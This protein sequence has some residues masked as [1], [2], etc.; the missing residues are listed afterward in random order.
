MESTEFLRIPTGILRTNEDA[1][2]SVT[3]S[4]QIRMDVARG[5]VR[6]KIDMSNTAAYEQIRVEPS[7]VWKTVF[8]TVYG[9]FMSHTMQIGDCNAPATF[10]R[11]MTAIF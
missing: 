11:L 10:Q 6:S 9:T 8:A 2:G 3:C 5:K 4:E 1:W 7:D